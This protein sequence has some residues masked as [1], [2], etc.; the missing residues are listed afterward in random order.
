M[1][2]SVVGSTYNVDESALMDAVKTLRQT[3]KEVC[4]RLIPGKEAASARDMLDFAL[5]EFMKNCLH[6]SDIEI[7][8]VPLGDGSTLLIARDIAGEDHLDPELCGHLGV[9]AIQSIV[10][11][12]NYHLSFDGTRYS[13]FLRIVPDEIAARF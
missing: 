4:A 5:F 11:H 6:G 3:S 10:G 7:L 9:G 8:E 1:V 13:A 12:D 2:I